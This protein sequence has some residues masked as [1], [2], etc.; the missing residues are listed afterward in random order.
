MA[1][2]VHLWDRVENRQYTELHSKQQKSKQP[3]NIWLNFEFFS[4]YF[5]KKLSKIYQEWLF[6]ADFVNSGVFRYFV[7]VATAAASLL[8]L[9]RKRNSFKYPVVGKL[10]QTKTKQFLNHRFPDNKKIS[11]NAP[12]FLSQSPTSFSSWVPR[13]ICLLWCASVHVFLVN[14]WKILV[15]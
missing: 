7:R 10:N 8:F 2:L 13:S 9:I 1:W 15:V 5:F 12:F 3:V 14:N 4:V 11:L 6:V